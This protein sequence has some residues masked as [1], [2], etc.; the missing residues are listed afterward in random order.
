MR[1]LYFHLVHGMVEYW[2][3]DFERKFII[4]ILHVNLNFPKPNIPSF[5]YSNIPIGAKPLSST[6]FW[7][8][9]PKIIF[10]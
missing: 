5:Q 1:G 9:A 7:G 6:S 8:Q 3:V 2:N 4:Y 10:Y